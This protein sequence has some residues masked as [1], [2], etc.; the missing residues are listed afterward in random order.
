MTTE[1]LN[2]TVTGRNPIEGS[3]GASVVVAETTAAGAPGGASLEPIGGDSAAAAVVAHTDTGTLLSVDVP[4]VK[5]KGE[6]APETGEKV[7]NSGE[8]KKPETEVVPEV[9]VTEV[10]EPVAYADFTLPEGT[11]I[12]EDRLGD[13]H[14]ILREFNLP[15]EA[16]QK[17]LDMHIK[18]IQEITNQ[19]QESIH[20]AQ[21]A[22]FAETR[23][24]WRDQVMADEQLGGAGHQT[25]MAAVKRMASDFVPEADRAAFQQFLLV[26]GAGDNPAFLRLLHNIA[27]KFDEP[28]APAVQGNPPPNNGKP[29][30][31][32]GMV[33]DHPRSNTAQG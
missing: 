12:P 29:P 28:K 26:T 27:Q 6:I 32:R 25:A 21:H 3:A 15:Q 7:V 9:V 24:G 5:V 10:T 17:F 16:G 23:K 4:E 1:A 22:A 19:T 13:Y 20:Q 18:A 11:A 8:G 14:N 30:S 33:Y 31:R 2:E